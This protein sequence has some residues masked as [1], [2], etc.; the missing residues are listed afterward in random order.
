MEASRLYETTKFANMVT[1]VVSRA[2][3]NMTP[4]NPTNDID[5]EIDEINEEDLRRFQQLDRE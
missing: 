2:L 3:R 1:G 4:S 5:V